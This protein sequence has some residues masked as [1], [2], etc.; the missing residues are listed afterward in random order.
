MTTRRGGPAAEYAA[1]GETLFGTTAAAYARYRPGKPDAA[2]R[3]RAAPLHGVPAPVPVDLVTRT[4]QVPCAPLTVVRRLAHVDLMDAHPGVLAQAMA[5]SRAVLGA[6]TTSSYGEVRTVTSQPADRGPDLIACRR[7][8]LRFPVA[9]P[10]TPETVVGHLR[11]TSFAPPD[12][13]SDRHEAFE[14]EARTRQLLD[15]YTKRG[16]LREAAALTVLLGRRPGS[17]R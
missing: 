17:A 15:A 3:V 2:V 9:R 10:W 13:F 11:R 7:A 14:F 1:C 16:V 4:A 8:F 12:L 5:E 6:G